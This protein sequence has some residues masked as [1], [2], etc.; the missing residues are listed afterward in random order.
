MQERYNIEHG[1]TPKTVLREISPL[2]EEV[3]YE[4]GE[5]RKSFQRG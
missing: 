2:L 1:I 5:G 3:T 4:V